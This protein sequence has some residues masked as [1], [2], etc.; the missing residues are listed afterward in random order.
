[1]IQDQ[2]AYEVWKE[3]LA[4]PCPL[5]LCKAQVGEFCSSTTSVIHVQRTAKVIENYKTLRTTNNQL[6][7]PGFERG[8][9]GT[10]TC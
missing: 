7:L 2:V 4:I 9:K 3:E 1:M 8:L 10:S 6:S 5:S